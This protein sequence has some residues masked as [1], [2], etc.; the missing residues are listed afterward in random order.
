[1]A[2]GDSTGRNVGTPERGE[3]EGLLLSAGEW[4]LEGCRPHWAGQRPPWWPLTVSTMGPRTRRQIH[5]RGPPLPSR[6]PGPW[7]GP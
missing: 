3:R 1:M 6:C 2:C 4:E 5:L 7:P